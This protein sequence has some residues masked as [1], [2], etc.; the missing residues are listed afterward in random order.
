MCVQGQKAQIGRTR[1]RY[2]QPKS[3]QERG[4]AEQHAFE[5]VIQGYSRNKECAIEIVEQVEAAGGGVHPTQRQTNEWSQSTHGGRAKRFEK[6]HSGHGRA[7]QERTRVVPA[8]N[9]TPLELNQRYTVEFVAWGEVYAATV[10]ALLQGDAC[11]TEGPESDAPLPQK[12]HH[13]S[14]CAPT[15][16]EARR[17]RQTLHRFAG[18][19]W[20][21]PGWAE[22]AEVASSQKTDSWGESR[23][24]LLLRQCQ[25]LQLILQNGLPQ[26]HLLSRQTQQPTLRTHR[27]ARQNAPVA[28]TGLA[29]AITTQD[30][31]AIQ[32]GVVRPWRV[33]DEP[34][35]ESGH[36][37]AL[38][39][40]QICQR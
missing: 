21:P 19:S 8:Q 34:I 22:V 14:H 16:R 31:L 33:E 4:V 24:P 13:S 2:R 7:A 6:L 17:E 29:L 1:H 27:T 30:H 20:A 25:L 38:Q 11:L 40:F 3:W 37:D 18:H 9:P 35:W 39:R 23:V 10:A 32:I 28:A 5:W 36:G 12:H 15:H 26:L